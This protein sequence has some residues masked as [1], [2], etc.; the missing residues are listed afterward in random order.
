MV[1]RLILLGRCIASFLKIS[2]SLF[3]RTQDRN[4]NVCYNGYYYYFFKSLATLLLNNLLIL[5]SV[6]TQRSVA[7]E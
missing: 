4:H 6:E 3:G 2:N 7:P 1:N 5:S